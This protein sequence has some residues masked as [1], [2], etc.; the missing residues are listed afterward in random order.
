MQNLI[1]KGLIF[2][3]VRVADSF[4]YLAQDHVVYTLS[5][6]AAAYCIQNIQCTQNEKVLQSAECLK[7]RLQTTRKTLS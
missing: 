7:K 3:V 6:L 4:T 2:G 5:W 1:N